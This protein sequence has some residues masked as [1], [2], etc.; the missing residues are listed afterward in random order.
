MY[1]TYFIEC[2]DVPISGR[3]KLCVSDAF[4]RK[5][6]YAVGKYACGKP[7]L[8]VTPKKSLIPMCLIEGMPSEDQPL[9]GGERD[10]VFD[11]IE[12]GSY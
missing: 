7:L 2:H 6:I 1:Y 12:G 11:Q 8:S 3:M 4:S 9:T 5:G 10:L